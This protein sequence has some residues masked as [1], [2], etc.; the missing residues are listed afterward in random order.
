M[1]RSS[2]TC[3][4]SSSPCSPNTALNLSRSYP[5][6]I[7]LQ[8]VHILSLCAYADPVVS[9]SPLHSVEP[10]RIIYSVGSPSGPR[11]LHT[12]SLAPRPFIARPS[13]INSCT[14]LSLSQPAIVELL[15]KMGHD[16]TI[17]ASANAH[18]AFKPINTTAENVANPDDIIHVLVPP[19]RPDI[20]H[21]CDIMEEVAVAYGFNNLKRTFPSTSTVAKPFPLN[22]LSDTM[23]RLCSEAGWTEVLPL[24]L[25]CTLIF[26]HL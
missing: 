7:L 3:W 4:M 26:L 11:I 2:H 1:R 17:P 10:V 16:A 21:E 20:L 25:V 5:F 14:G 12:P 15:R 18:A 13:Y 22:K 8:H 6:N 24:I 19:T 23:R 9:A